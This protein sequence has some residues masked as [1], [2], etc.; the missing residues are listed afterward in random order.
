MQV[1]ENTLGNVVQYPKKLAGFFRRVM[2]LRPGQYVI[3]LTVKKNNEV[4]YKLGAL[5]SYEEPT[6]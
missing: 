1:V 3:I 5:T 6:K 4:V 2:G